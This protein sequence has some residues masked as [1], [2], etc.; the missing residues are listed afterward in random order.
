[1]AVEVLVQDLWC[2][3]LL[4]LVGRFEGLLAVLGRTHVLEGLLSATFI[5]VAA[6]HVVILVCVVAGV[7]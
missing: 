5:Q 3:E 7:L 6:L 1:M 2:L 4:V